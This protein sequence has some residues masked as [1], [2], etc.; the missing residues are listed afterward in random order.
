MF[1][2]R[3]GRRFVLRWAVPVLAL[4]LAVGVTTA[5][6]ASTASR[7]QRASAIWADPPRQ[8]GG[9]ACHPASLPYKIGFCSVCVLMSAA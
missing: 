2:P 5:A 6:S 3:P 8:P 9:S 7:R 1:V 4:W